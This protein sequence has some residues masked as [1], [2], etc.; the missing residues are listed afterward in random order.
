[1]CRF[2]TLGLLLVATAGHVLG[3]AGMW[4][5]RAAGADDDWNV[6]VRAQLNAGNAQ[7]ALDLTE[8]WMG[9]APKDMDAVG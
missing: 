9:E 1:M 4:T 6:R 8:K 5:V 3:S 2:A 7:A